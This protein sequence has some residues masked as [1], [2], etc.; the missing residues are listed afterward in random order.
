LAATAIAK[1]HGVY[2]AS[3]TRLKAREEMSKVA[4]SDDVSI[5]DGA[6][7]KQVKEKFDEIFELVGTTTLRD[8]LRCVKEGG[9]VRMAG[10]VG[11]E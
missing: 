11:N 4:G 8:S 6:I 10:I 2:V 7:A 5:D 1:N 3:T 9:T